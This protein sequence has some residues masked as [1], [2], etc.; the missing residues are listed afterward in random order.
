MGYLHVT[1]SADGILHKIAA[2]DDIDSRTRC[3][4]AYDYLK[5][6][7]SSFYR[8]FVHLR[9]CLLHDGQHLNIFNFR[10]TQGIECAFWPNLYP[11][12]H[13]CETMLN[14]GTDRRSAKV[15]FMTKVFSSIVHYAMSFDFFAFLS[16]QY[17]SMA[18]HGS[19]SQS[20]HTSG[21]SLSQ[22]G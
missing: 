2:F 16:M 12:T 10:M 4:Q 13:W 1:L 15:S 20:A 3:Q 14:G 5:S 18:F 21:R 8:Y 9:E 17:S 6:A 22:N 19:S 7:D 11:F